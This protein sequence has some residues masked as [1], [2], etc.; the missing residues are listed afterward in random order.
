MIYFFRNTYTYYSFSNES[1]SFNFQINFRSVSLK[2]PSAVK[3]RSK[4]D[5]QDVAI[6]TKLGQFPKI[7]QSNPLILMK[8]L[9]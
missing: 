3:D 6:S 1:K 2:Y 7:L 9:A 8:Y 5:F 4:P